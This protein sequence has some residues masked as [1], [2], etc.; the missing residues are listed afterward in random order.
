MDLGHPSRSRRR[1]PARPRTDRH[2]GPRRLEV[3]AAVD[4]ETL[5]EI[6]SERLD[7]PIL[8]L[9]ELGAI[10]IAVVVVVDPEAQVVPGAVGRGEL[11]V[12]VAPGARQIEIGE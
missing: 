10:R 1:G 12:A 3:Q 8:E 11:T 5:R 6:E 2:R 4:L 7:A 9:V